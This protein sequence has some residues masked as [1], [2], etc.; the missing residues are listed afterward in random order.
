MPGQAG[1]PAVGEAAGIGVTARQRR[2]ERVRVAE[3][4]R[5]SRVGSACCSRGGRLAGS[6]DGPRLARMPAEVDRHAVGFGYGPAVQIACQV[7]LGF[8]HWPDLAAFFDD[9]QA[10]AVR[11]PA[12]HAAADLFTHQESSSRDSRRSSATWAFPCTGS[13]LTYSRAWT[14]TRRQPSETVSW[15]SFLKV[16]AAWRMVHL[17]WVGAI[18]RPHSRYR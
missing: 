3:R 1:L 8:P 2:H 17:S 5:I 7:T 15:T 12:Q 14:Q 13:T 9:D 4:I 6:P 16:P 18:G 10:V 11:L